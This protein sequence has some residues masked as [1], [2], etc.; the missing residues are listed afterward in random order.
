MSKKAM[1]ASVEEVPVMPTSTEEAKNEQ[2]EVVVEAQGNS[3]LAP[4]AKHAVEGYF[5]EKVYG[6]ARGVDQTSSVEEFT[7]AARECYLS[8]LDKIVDSGAVVGARR[9]KNEKSQGKLTG[10]ITWERVAAMERATE[11][12]ALE[13]HGLNVFREGMEDMGAM[14]VVPAGGAYGCLA[15]DVRDW[16]V[17]YEQK[18]S[19]S[20]SKQLMSK[21]CKI[22]TDMFGFRWDGGP[23]GNLYDG[24]AIVSMEASCTSMTKAILAELAEEKAAQEAE[25]A[26]RKAD[27]TDASGGAGGEMEEEEGIWV[28]HPTKTDTVVISYS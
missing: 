24:K 23:N 25:A 6:V 9:P 1:M 13:K 22:Q 8:A 14:V 19:G 28:A 21:N 4:V 10:A 17:E 18:H 15:G 20:K 11:D 7:D 16:L 3:V 26:K 27:G 5:T 2:S 12:E